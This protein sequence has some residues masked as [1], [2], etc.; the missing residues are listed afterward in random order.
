MTKYLQKCKDCNKYGLANPE[1]KCRYCG[2]RLVST[3]PPKF[4]LTD[5]Y[6]SYRI[7]YFKEEFDEKFK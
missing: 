7:K 1:S 4:S 6:G 5:K 3:R 2:G